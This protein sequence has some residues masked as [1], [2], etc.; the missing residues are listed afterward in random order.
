MSNL[1]EWQPKTRLGR[2][3]K[4]G[5]ITSIEEVFK[6]NQP[7]KEVEIVESLLPNLQEEVI[8]LNLVQRQTDAGEIG[9]FKATV[10]VG[11]GDGYIGFGEAKAKEVGP[12]I[13]LAI[14]KA[15]LNIRPVRRGC[16]S[17]ECGCGTSHS[18]LFKT[19]GRA[20]SV[21]ITL[22]PAPKGVGL[23]VADSIKLVL[24]LAGIKDVWCWSKGHTR[25]TFNFA[26]A[27]YDALKN[28]YNIMTPKDWER[29]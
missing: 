13:R 12:A 26:K 14:I 22:I 3:V 20:G 29:A 6:L 27:A 17:W 10:V 16:G 23:V 9:R 7:I 2:M 28:T 1:D 21:R 19:T 25:T 18:L 11:N 5:K 4:D 15:K 24:R 8:D